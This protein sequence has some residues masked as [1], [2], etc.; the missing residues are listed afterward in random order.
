MYVRMYMHIHSANAHTVYVLPDAISY[1]YNISF[2]L[3][4]CY[5][6]IY[7]SVCVYTYA[8]N[9]QINTYVCVYI[10]IYMCIYI[11]YTIYHN[12]SN[13]LCTTMLSCV[14]SCYVMLHYVTWLLCFALSP[15]LGMRGVLR[16]SAI[17]PPVVYGGF[18]GV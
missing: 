17:C 5:A 14:V 3:Y 2:I 12:V 18:G 7:I 9:I 8:D 4:E 15:S 13:T 11:S 1:I 6:Y 16:P 10:H